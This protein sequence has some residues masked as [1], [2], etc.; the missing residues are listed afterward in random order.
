MERTFEKETV[1]ASR[2]ARVDEERAE[3][4][5]ERETVREA[6]RT[7]TEEERAVRQRRRKRRAALMVAVRPIRFRV[8]KAKMPI[9]SRSSV[10]DPETNGSKP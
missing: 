8:V 2:L 6:R 4:T 5:V 1:R 10:S 9:A 7:R 3:R